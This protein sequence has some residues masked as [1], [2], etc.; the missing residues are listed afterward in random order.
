MSKLTPLELANIQ[1]TADLHNSSLREVSETHA[2]VTE[3]ASA[4]IK[5]A[6]LY[7]ASKGISDLTIVNTMLQMCAIWLHGIHSGATSNA[8]RLM[9]DQIEAVAKGDEETEARICEALMVNGLSFTAAVQA[10]RKGG[11]N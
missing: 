6:V 7:A 9:A 5:N 11:R 3:I 2:L 10:E 8:L 1:R 4:S